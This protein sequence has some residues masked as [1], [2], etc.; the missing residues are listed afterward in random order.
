MSLTIMDLD[1]MDERNHPDELKKSMPVFTIVTTGNYDIFKGYESYKEGYQSVNNVPRHI[2]SCLVGTFVASQPLL[3]QC[4]KIVVEQQLADQGYGFAKANTANPSIVAAEQAIYS[5]LTAIGVDMEKI[6]CMSSKSKFSHFPNN[7]RGVVYTHCTID[8]YAH[9]KQNAAAI[10][11]AAVRRE[12]NEHNAS[13]FADGKR[14]STGTK[15][16]IF[17]MCDSAG[18]CLVA[19]L[20]KQGVK[21]I[22]AAA[23]RKRAAELESIDANDPTDAPA[24]RKRKPNPKPDP[25]AKPKPKRNPKPKANP[26]AKPNPKPSVPYG[27]ILDYV[28]TTENGVVILQRKK[29]EE[30][31][32]SVDVLDLTV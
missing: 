12:G 20:E 13:L 14:A 15:G 32:A 3:K 10:M 1:E 27:A 8:S 16:K 4:D 17:D 7:F 26:K 30:N 19:F 25:K 24:P 28:K 6:R 18:L 11:D 22:T 29:S 2:I 23:K 31:E 5:A 21:P 9:R